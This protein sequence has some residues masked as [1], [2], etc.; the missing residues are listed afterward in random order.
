ME[1][2]RTEDEDVATI[3]IQKRSVKLIPSPWSAQLV[4]VEN[5]KQTNKQT[6]KTPSLVFV[7]KRREMNC[8]PLVMMCYDV[9]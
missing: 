7:Q 9:T 2:H 6:N 5:K 8:F 4:A 3:W 1:Q